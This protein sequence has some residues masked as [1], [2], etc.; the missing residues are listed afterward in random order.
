MPSVSIQLAIPAAFLYAWSIRMHGKGPSA[1]IQNFHAFVDLI[2]IV[3]GLKRNAE[4]CTCYSHPYL[5]APIRIMNIKYQMLNGDILS[6]K[7]FI[8]KKTAC[9]VS[10]RKC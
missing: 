9:F 3:L 6:R 5:L 10:E 2:K 8:E 1:L 4:F 7:T